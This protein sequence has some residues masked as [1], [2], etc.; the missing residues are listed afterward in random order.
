MEES[1]PTRTNAAD[2][3]AELPL[4]F[5]D[6]RVRHKEYKQRQLGS[7]AASRFPEDP[8]ETRTKLSARLD[9]VRSSP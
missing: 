7:P 9:A 5:R 4:E 3:P 1:S 6:Q 2:V 8:G